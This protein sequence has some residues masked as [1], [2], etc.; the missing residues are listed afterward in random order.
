MCKVGMESFDEGSVFIEDLPM[1]VCSVEFN[2]NSLMCIF[3][4]GLPSLAPERALA[5]FGDLS[6]P[7]AFG[8]KVN[9]EL[10][11]ELI[12]VQR[13]GG[14]QQIFK[15]FCSC[16]VLESSATILGIVAIRFFP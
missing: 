10:W 13:S 12:E 11:I 8:N 3:Q 5:L 15:Y 7:T 16:F 6:F 4:S 14:L 2:A 9:S 1:I